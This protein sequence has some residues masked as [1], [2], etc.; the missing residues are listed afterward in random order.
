ME[1]ALDYLDLLAHRW[2]PEVEQL[3]RARERAGMRHGYEDLQLRKIQDHP[4]YR[5]HR[6]LASRIR[7]T[8]RGAKS[9][10]RDGTAGGSDQ[11]GQQGILLEQDCT[12]VEQQPAVC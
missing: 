4:V 3:G 1:A 12:E 6:E 7:P 10:G 8:L 11:V 9:I 2:L 5:C